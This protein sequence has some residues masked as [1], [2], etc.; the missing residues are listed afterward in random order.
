[1]FTLSS[2]RPVGV[3][4]GTGISRGLKNEPILDTTLSTPLKMILHKQAMSWRGPEW[5]GLE[6]AQYCHNY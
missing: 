2:I 3:L 1:M 5:L 6:S 4:A